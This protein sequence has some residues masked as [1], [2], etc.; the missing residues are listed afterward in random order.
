MLSAFL[1][2]YPKEPDGAFES[3]S[4]KIRGKLTCN[5]TCE[6]CLQTLQKSNDVVLDYYE[7]FFPDPTTRY[8]NSL[9]IDS[10][11]LKGPEFQSDT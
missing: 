5:L 9:S 8:N 10:Y 1:S 7:F 2:S 4:L 3:S 11:A 6:F